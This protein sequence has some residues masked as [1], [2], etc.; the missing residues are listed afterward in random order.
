MDYQKR[1]A[2]PNPI[3][4]LIGG[5]HAPPGGIMGHAGAWAEPG[6]RSSTGKIRALERA[7]VV[8]V[9]HPERFGTEMKR[10][11]EFSG[12]KKTVAG[13]GAIQ[14]RELHTFRQR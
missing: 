1:K 7:G 5:I 6:K 13:P 10:L 4:G 3:M 9:D 2:N 12:N 14:R 11:L 8:T